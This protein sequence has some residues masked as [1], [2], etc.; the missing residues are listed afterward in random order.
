MVE[1]VIK[2]QEQFYILA[3]SSLADDRTRVL[4][5]GETFAVFDRFGDIQGIGLSRQG[6]FHEGTRYLSRCVL[7]LNEERPLLL[8]SGIK[9]DNAVLTVDLSNPDTS[10]DGQVVVAR[11]TLH[12]LRSKFLWKGACYETV[13]LRN[14][15]L[16]PLDVRF[17]VRFDADFADIFE[18]RG[19]ARARRGRRL[20]DRVEDGAILMSYEGLDRV[21]RR[22]R[23]TAT[24][25]P[26]ETKP[27]LMR[28]F[29]HL[30]AQQ[31]AEYSIAVAC[32]CS[33]R[34]SVATG[35]NEALAEA[36]TELS[37][38]R[39]RDCDLYTANEQFND[40]VNRSASDLHMM[41]TQTTDMLYPY[42]G[43]PWFSAVFGRDG[44]ITAFQYLWVNPVIAEGVLKYLA[45]TQAAAE[46]PAQ[47]A[48]PGKILHEQR[49]GEMAEM[50][51]HPFKRYYGTVDATPLFVMLAA[52]Y[53]K[54]TGDL[55]L[56]RSI[57]PNIERALRWMDT[58]GD[59]DGDGFIEYSRRSE[60]GLVQQGWKDSQDSVFHADGRMAE[61]PIALCEVQAYAFAAKEGAAAL[62]AA[63]GDKT[64]AEELAREAVDLRDAFDAAFWD[65]RLSMYVLALDGEKRQCKVRASNAGHCLFAR[66]A[67]TDRAAPL[68]DALLAS[69]MF[70]GWGV[71]TLSM[72]EAR[73]NPMSYHNGSVW[74]HDN[75]LI[76]YGLGRYGFQELAGR[77]MTGLFDAALFID[78]HR[79]PELFCGFGR[80]TGEGP[81]LYPVACSPQ[82]WAAGSAFLLLQACLGL[83]IDAVE[84]QVRFQHAWLPEFLPV[85]EL[86]NLCIGDARVDLR[87]ERHP[88]SVGITVL[89]RKG[90]I[91]ILSV[92]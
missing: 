24:P 18:V 38:L 68:A 39:A 61:P 21:V 44:L 40:F 33:E 65:E 42:A 60:T 36:N 90:K 70:S 35:Y 77:I 4:K 67:R 41:I 51:E 11:G 53:Y 1:D 17:S 62:A 23:I 79:L 84:R 27:S 56:I 58:Y 54:R 72:H 28:F 32:E 34:G 12:L 37:A 9:E 89:G 22:T 5:N 20:E 47:D 46:D 86:R 73:Y 29:A 31:E 13:R 81:T 48:E 43:V 14:Y 78:Q 59:R 10:V 52:A 49:S 2:V 63:L 16:T 7:R 3:G 64:R 85:L 57:W 83:E 45:K 15:G 74:P 80:R 88:Y 69:D 87:L 55:E 8:S 50:G 91:D 82:A 6:L 26:A 71:R 76:A 30:E 75:S 19:L 66:V 25:A 92:K